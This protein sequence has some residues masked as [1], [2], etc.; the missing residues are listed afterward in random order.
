MATDFGNMFEML[1]EA[2]TVAVTMHIRPD[3]DSI[4]TALALKEALKAMGKRVWVFSE[5]IDIAYQNNFATISGFSKIAHSNSIE[6]VHTDDCEDT[7]CK[8]HIRFTHNTPFTEVTLPCID[9]LVVVDA[10]EVHRLGENARLI[11]YSKKVL[12]F[13][14]H[15]NANMECD[16]LVQ[17]IERASCGEMMYEFFA[18]HNIEISKNMAEALYTAVSSDTG[19]FLFP[20]TTW[21][22]HH[23]A[24]ELMKLNIDVAGINYR[25]FRA[26]EPKSLEGFMRVLSEIK[27]LSGGRITLTYLSHSLIQ[28]YQFDHEER[29]RFQKFATDAKGVMVSI[30]VQEKE[31]G[32]FN[33]SLRSVGDTNVAEI[34]QNFGGGGHKNAAGLQMKGR[35]KDIVKDLLEH[36]ERAIS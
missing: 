14:H 3:G 17:N 23:V 32:E 34:A 12:I 13:D 20:N 31:K 16:T 6:V 21:Y 36:V 11:G 1:Q 35:Y 29:H 25:N 8:G 26:Y 22:T 28:K 9:L 4:G 2:E 15:L 30:F 7:N 18:E 19:C 33:I 10:G 27:F 24:S 5:D